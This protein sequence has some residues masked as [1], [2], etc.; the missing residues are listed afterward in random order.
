MI[1][2]RVYIETTIPSF[3][4]DER[5][6]PEIVARRSWTRQWWDRF[7]HE[8][9]RVTSEAVTKELAKG[10]PERLPSWLSLLAGLPLLPMD[11][12]VV[13]ISST[14]CAHRLMP[15]D[16]SG[17][18]LH[19][20]FASYYKCDFLVTWNCV[21]MA[22]ARKFTHL[23]RVSNMLGLFVPSIVTPLELLGGRED[24]IP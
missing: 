13:D 21:H 20:A 19:V 5:T 22:N 16:P 17:N 1:K 15:D 18:A 8:Y 2:P 23:R 9:E 7:G 4:Y 6:D 14:Y 12:A 3:Y 10:P 24:E 11:P